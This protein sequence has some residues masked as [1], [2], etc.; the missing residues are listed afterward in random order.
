MCGYLDP[1]HMVK[2]VRNML[3][4]YWELVWPNRGIVKWA[5]IVRL[6]EIQNEHHGLRLANKL[7]Q[8]HINYKAH[9]MKVYLATQILSRSVE[10]SLRWHHEQKT[11]GFESPNVLVTA[12]FVSLHND[13]FDV[14]N[15][16]A[17][18]SPGL[19]AALTVDNLHRAQE[20]FRELEQL[21]EVL[22]GPGGKKIIHSR[23][24]TG[25][26]GFLCAFKTVEKLVGDMKRGTLDLYFLRCYRLQQDS[27]CIRYG[28]MGMQ[29]L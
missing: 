13:C 28:T 11:P 17:L 10:K 26:M 4:E 20:K 15:S 25:P 2:L 14:L 22:Q 7:T 24:K 19:K 5:Y 23:R 27:D 6:Q 21:Y 18:G 12:D 29:N 16:R 8:K 1:P 9:K 3:A